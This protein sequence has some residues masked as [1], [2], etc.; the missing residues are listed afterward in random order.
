MLIFN[1]SKLIDPLLK[2]IRVFTLESAEIKKGDRILDVCC[3]TGDQA[4]YYIKKGAIVTG[5]DL[6][7][8][9]IEVALSRKQKQEVSDIYFKVADAAALPF[10]DHIFDKASIS[11]ALHEIE[12]SKRDAAIS[13]MKRVV[14]K[15]GR[16]I[17]I[18]FKVPF[19]SNAASYL[20]KAAE[21]LGGKN[22]RESLKSYIEEGG[23]PI[24]LGRN[25]L[26]QEKISYFK[27]GLLTIIKTKNL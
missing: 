27:D 10:E 5:I 18:D 2:D 16:L 26:K 11:L 21:Y 12:S 19:V 23:L 4:F 8:K 3:G 9:M 24:L 1:Y 6:N 20:I 14:K 25:K 15:D 22:N 17:F 7:P 13:E